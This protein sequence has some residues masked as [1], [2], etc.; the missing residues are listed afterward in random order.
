MPAI[1]RAIR[2]EYDKLDR[3]MSLDQFGRYA[4]LIAEEMKG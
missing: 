3:A 4:S 1:V 2:R